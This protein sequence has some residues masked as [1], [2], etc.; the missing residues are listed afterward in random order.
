MHHT[1]QVEL[2]QATDHHADWVLQFHLIYS[3][4]QL[5]VEKHKT[6]NLAQRP[7]GGTPDVPI[8]KY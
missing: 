7:P 6:K 8:V 4:F 5:S 2:T 1:G 3:S